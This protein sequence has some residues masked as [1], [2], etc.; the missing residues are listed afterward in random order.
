MK[1]P[2][3]HI[4]IHNAYWASDTFLIDL[5]TK[6]AIVSINLHK[7]LWLKSV[8]Q[9]TLCMSL[10]LLSLENYVSNLIQMTM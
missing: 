9:R 2:E 10:L 6:F 7:V 3:H 5:E 8:I 1:G 4:E